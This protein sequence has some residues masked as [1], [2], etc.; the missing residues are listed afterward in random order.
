MNFQYI[1][2][3]PCTDIS[4]YNDCEKILGDT[5]QLIDPTLHFPGEFIYFILIFFSLYEVS[6]DLY[7]KRADIFLYFCIVARPLCRVG[8]L[9]KRRVKESNLE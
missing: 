8:R 9:E 5:L 2:S 3:S 6:T 1:T 4:L 7:N